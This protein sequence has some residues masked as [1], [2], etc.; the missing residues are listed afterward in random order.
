MKQTGISFF[1]KYMSVWVSLGIVLDL[2]TLGLVRI[3]N[4]TLSWFE[5]RVY[6]ALS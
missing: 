5:P 1:R 6:E 2:L 4:K 3:V